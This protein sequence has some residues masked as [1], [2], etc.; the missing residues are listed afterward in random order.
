MSVHCTDSQ[1]ERQMNGQIVRQKD[2]WMDIYKGCIIQE[3]LSQLSRQ[4]DTCC[5]LISG[6][7]TMSSEKID[8]KVVLYKSSYDSQIDRQIA[9]QLDTCCLL[10]SGR[11][12][13]SS[14]KIDTKVVLYRSSEHRQI[15]GQV[16]SQFRQLDIQIARQ[17]D[18]CC[19]LIS[20]RRTISSEKIDTKV[21]SSSN[22][23]QVLK[24]CLQLNS[25]EKVNRN[26]DKINVLV[27]LDSDQNLVMRSQ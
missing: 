7:R 14:Q 18:T 23:E 6:S 11:R 22:S 8:T 1:I 10:I 13:M 26:Q 19:L 2:G 21:V 3:L 17:I 4:I 12:T 5:L 27:I 25:P 20:G 9:R 16:D 15:D 24:Y